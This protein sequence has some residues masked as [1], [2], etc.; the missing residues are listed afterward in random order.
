MTKSVGNCGFGHFYLRILNGKL[1]FLYRTKYFISLILGSKTKL[2]LEV[3]W[4]EGDSIKGFTSKNIKVN[5]PPYIPPNGEF[6]I[7][8]SSGG[9]AGQTKFVISAEGIT[10]IDTPLKF[11][12]Y[13]RDKTKGEEWTLMGYKQGMNIAQHTTCIPR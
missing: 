11:Y 13:T 8:P 6:K 3:L 9:K 2:L 1:H 5:E 4:K 10:D 12:F 7:E